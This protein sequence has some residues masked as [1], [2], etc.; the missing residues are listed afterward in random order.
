[1]TALYY[2]AKGCP[3]RLPRNSSDLTSCFIGVSFFRTL[4]E[5]K[6]FTS[7]AQVFNERGDGFIVKGAEAKISKN[8]LKPY[9][10]SASAASL[11]QDALANYRSE[12]KTPPARLV[13]HKSSPFRKEE[14]DGFESVAAEKDIEVI[15]GVLSTETEMARE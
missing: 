12:H 7:V 9:L 13:I 11:L 10:D 15:K 14:L 2:K 1:M 3:W 8:D 4:D 6:M 5:K